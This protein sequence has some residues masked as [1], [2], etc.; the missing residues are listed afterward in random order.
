MKQHTAAMT[1]PAASIT[2]IFV[3]LVGLAGL[4][5]PGEVAAA[6]TAILGYV[7]VRVGLSR[8]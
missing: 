7:A 2:I 4:E 3:W 1:L 6:I 8:S 5:V